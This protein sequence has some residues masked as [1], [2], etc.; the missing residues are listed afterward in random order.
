MSILSDFSEGGFDLA[1]SIIG[2]NGF[3][4]GSGQALNVVKSEAR[5]DRESEMGGFERSESVPVVVNTSTFTQYYTANIRTYQGRYCSLDGVDWK[6][7][8][9][10]Q[11]DVFTTFTLISREEVS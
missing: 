11:G 4:I 10:E 7:G 6:I 3:A 9:I 2:T 8:D 1:K 5:I